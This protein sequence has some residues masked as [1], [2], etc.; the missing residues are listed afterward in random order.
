M[1][2]DEGGEVG[3]GVSGFCGVLW[4][5]REPV[6]LA[7][8]DEEE[9]EEEATEATEAVSDMDIGLSR[10]ESEKLLLLL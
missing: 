6:E 3:V 7:A 1:G 8:E 10:L 5:E 2:G 9:E 4:P